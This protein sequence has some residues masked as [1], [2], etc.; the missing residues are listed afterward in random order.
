MDPTYQSR[1]LNFPWKFVRPNLSKANQH[2]TIC[3]NGWIYGKQWFWGIKMWKTQDEMIYHVTKKA[4]KIDKSEE[5]ITCTLRIG[6]RICTT[7]PNGG[8]DFNAAQVLCGQLHIQFLLQIS[9][10]SYMKF[11]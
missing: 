10:T 1:Q 6:G 9:T 7:I 11:T 4:S 8:F 3:T 5:D 2:W